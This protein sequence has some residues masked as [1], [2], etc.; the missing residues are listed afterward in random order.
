M[1]AQQWRGRCRVLAA[2]L[3]CS[4]LAG[5]LLPL[6]AASAGKLD[7]IKARGTLLVGVTES[8]PPFSY[9][10]GGNGIVG[11]DVDLAGQVAKRLGVA[12][13]KVPI[14]NADRISRCKVTASIWSRSA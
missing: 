8:S 2:I 3:V 10:D 5:S 4:L 1:I 11:Y 14:I 13:A 6:A 9:R 12:M 7:A